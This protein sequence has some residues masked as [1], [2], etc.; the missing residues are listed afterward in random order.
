MSGRYES[1]PPM[2]SS[3]R[4]IF[5]E[6]D[7]TGGLRSSPTWGG[8]DGAPT[9]VA[10]LLRMRFFLRRFAVPRRDGL[11]A[12]AL[13]VVAMV[14]VA[15][16]GLH[17][18]WASVPALTVLM[19]SLAW[20][21]RL[22]LRVVVVG[23][24]AVLLG[25]AAGMSLH[26]PF[27]PIIA[28]LVA[29]YS[30][31]LYAETGP[32]LLGLGYA[33]ACVF[34]AIGFAVRNGESFAGSDFGFFA[35]IFLAAWL[36]GKALHGRVTHMEALEDRAERAERD[37]EQRAREAARA[38]RSRIAR[39]LHDVI[40][41]SVSVMV[42][43][44]GAAEELLRGSGDALEPIQAVQ[45]TGRAALSET[46]RLLGMLRRDG[47][48]IG[49]EPQPG[50]DDLLKLVE[51]T[52][53]AGLPVELC[54]VGEPRKLSLGADLSAYRIVQEA[55][56][57]ARKHAHDAR[58]TVTVRFNDEALEIEVRDDGRAAPGN[59]AGGGHGL[60]GM[61]E[62]VALFGGVLQAGPDKGGGFRVHARLPVGDGQ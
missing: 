62:R 39:E 40:A 36:V 47:D 61:R 59:S 48:E 52:R 57:N 55:L 60:V 41:H 11:L 22:P 50:L 18:Y 4:L 1:A 19:G 6:L 34:G 27:S 23:F 13:W 24:G 21:R 9:G 8:R 25:V 26:G 2:S 20:R 42:V 37:R 17:P 15:T 51:E 45:A 58:A 44:A 7:S 30:L 35:A 28:F 43:Q 5:V 53:E 54:I 16:E 31:A 38:E 49:L 33:L 14:E 10:S 3:R 46:A 12:L 56:T 32:A 29:L